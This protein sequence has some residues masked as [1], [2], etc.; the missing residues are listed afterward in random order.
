MSWS[1]WGPLNRPCGHSRTAVYELRLVNGRAR[2]IS[3][4]R[5]LA[6]DDCGLLSIGETGNMESRRRQ[7]IRA[8]EKCSGHS[9]GNLLYYLLRHTPLRLR[10]PDHRLEYRFHKEPDKAAAKL[11]EARMIKAYI[12]KFGE[13]PPLNSAIPDRYGEWE[14]EDAR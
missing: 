9:E 6:I 7:F 13:A 5:F 11:A 1:D 12:R 8:L 4:P 3:L 2:P 14:Y 10:F